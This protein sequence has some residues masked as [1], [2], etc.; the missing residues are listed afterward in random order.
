MGK[1]KPDVGAAGAK[2]MRPEAKGGEA[3]P[4]KKFKP[5]KSHAPAHAAPQG[6]KQL[7]K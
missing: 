7:S 5:S 4:A 6:G 1:G 2:R 3:S